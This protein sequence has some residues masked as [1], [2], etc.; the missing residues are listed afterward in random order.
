MEVQ[1][2]SG[3]HEREPGELTANHLDVHLCKFISLNRTNM[4]IFVL[5]CTCFLVVS[6]GYAESETATTTTTTTTTTNP[7]GSTSTTVQETTTTPK[8]ET[9]A[10]EAEDATG[11]GRG[12]LV[13]PTGATGTIR[14][15]DRRQDRRS[16]DPRID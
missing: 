14:R 15:S 5:F 3:L 8:E 4:R 13:G 6:A 11:V 10:K 7:D 1:V 9:S 12:G 16:G 2:I